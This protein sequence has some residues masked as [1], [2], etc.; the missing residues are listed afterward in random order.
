MKKLADLLNDVSLR[1]R[2]ILKYNQAIFK[3]INIII[4]ILI[5]I[6]KNFKVM[7]K[8]KKCSEACILIETMIVINFKNF[9]AS[10]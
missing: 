9:M 1:I 10:K 6:K 8:T 7:L 2:E 3:I 4:I 5:I